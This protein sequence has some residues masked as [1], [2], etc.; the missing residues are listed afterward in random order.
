M[1]LSQNKRQRFQYINKE[2]NNLFTNTHTRP[3]ETLIPGDIYFIHSLHKRMIGMSCPSA[4]FLLENT[5]RIFIKFGIDG[6]N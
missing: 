6:L 1:S 5:G 3:Y 4:R 2:H